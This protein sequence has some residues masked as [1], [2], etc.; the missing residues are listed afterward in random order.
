MRSRVDCRE[1]AA[2]LGIRF[3]RR[4]GA[5]WQA[6][7]I[8][9]SAHAHGDRNASMGVGSDG[10]RCHGCGASGDVFTLYQAM[11]GV[12]FPTAVGELAERRGIAP[13]APR[14][15]A[16]GPVPPP[17]I[18]PPP[19]TRPAAGVPLLTAI[20]SILSDAPFTDRSREYLCRRGIRPEAAW[21]LGCRDWWARR[22]EIDALLAMSLP[23]EI[24]AAGLARESDGT[25]WWPL[26]RMIDGDATSAGVCAPV[27][28]PQDPAPLAWRWRLATP[29]ELRGGR[30]LKCMAQPGRGPA[31]LLGLRVPPARGHLVS[32]A[33]G[34]LPKARVVLICEGEPDW[35]ALT[36]AVSTLAPPREVAVVAS[37]LMSKPWD[38]SWTAHLLTAERVIIVTHDAHGP[39]IR[40]AVATGMVTALGVDE[41]RRRFR[42]S[43]LPEGNDAADRHHRGDLVALLRSVLEEASRA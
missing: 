23:G 34:R 19:Y 33:L 14:R 7:C 16:R 31:P 8:D 1:I 26:R 21:A 27:W 9:P 15:R 28:W 32:A 43:L 42:C 25:L 17:V 12:D 24:A 2:E 39:S 18:V 11:H 29:L 13:D 40:D 6:H 5:W 37:C 36:D 35:W 41:A 10:Y 3:R 22:H 20:W 30:R 4:S 38:S